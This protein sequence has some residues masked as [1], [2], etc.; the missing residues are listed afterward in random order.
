MCLPSQNI[1]D[2]PKFIFSGFVFDDEV[3]ETGKLSCREI[4]IPLDPDLDP[5]VLS[6]G[7][8]EAQGLLFITGP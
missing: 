5:R 8:V 7:K 2:T 1:S 6:T 4:K 3:R